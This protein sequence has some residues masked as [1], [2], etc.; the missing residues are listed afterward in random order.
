VALSSAQIAVG[1]TATE[2]TIPE[3]DRQEGA[4][5]TITNMGAATVFLG[6][7]GVTTATGFPL[8]AAATTPLVLGSGERV[9][10]VVAAGT[11]NVGVLRTGD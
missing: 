11:V 10:G 5:I 9:Y 6:P 4:A 7:A 8:A 1:T 2:L 3:A